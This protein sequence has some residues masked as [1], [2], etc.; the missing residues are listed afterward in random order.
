MSTSLLLGIDIGTTE[1]KGVLI[2]TDG[3]IVADAARE[4]TLYSEQPNWAEE[5]P[6]QWWTN[7]GS[8][9]RELIAKSGDRADSIVGVGVSGMVPAMVL[10]DDDGNIIR[11]SIQQNDARTARQ[12]EQVRG[13]YDPER[14]FAITGGSIN[15]QVVPP[16]ARW[17]HEHEPE[18]MARL[19]TLL[20]SYDFVNYRLTGV[21]GVDRN[22]ALES[23]L[24]DIAAEEWS[25]EL[26][27]LA[28]L[29]PSQ[30]PPIHASHE[31]IGSV[32]LE[33]AAITGLS[34]ST[35]VVAGAADHVA[36][37]FATTAY[38]DGD[39]VIKFGGAGDILYSLDRLV[40]DP[41]LF[42]DYHLVPGKYYLNG[43]MATSGSLVKWLVR[44][45]CASD[46]E[47]AAR[48]GQ[49]VYAYLDERAADLPAGAQGLVVLPYF[50]G[51]KTP[52][53]DPHARGTI[54]GLGLHHTRH[55]LFRAVLEAVAYGF[56]HHVDVLRERGLEIR[57]VLAAD[58]GARSDLWLQIAADVLGH[59]VERIANHPG[60]SLGAAIA[61]GVGT[62]ALPDW[63]SVERYVHPSRT[64]HP[65]EANAAVY[66]DIYAVY[67][68][69]YARLADLFPRLPR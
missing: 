12:I 22:W 34:A 33:A 2:D 17:L 49:D 67:R 5:D 26:I 52:L 60:S 27:E 53:H 10:L 64:F 55:H 44:N 19:G 9:T 24:F 3:A 1:T 69:T 39:L 63:R 15:Q 66:D 13:E 36:S 56:R 25:A 43:C 16:K 30:L 31:V 47:A 41:R 38:E 21:R 29:Q 61:A 37:A 54:V 57:R 51:E 46:A 48:L 28:R 18:T 68:E 45:F 7:V 42:I 20:G 40:T 6:E 8:I 50:L 14:F 4:A 62:G 65:N 35:P 59:P 58:G 32:T 23:G 11:R